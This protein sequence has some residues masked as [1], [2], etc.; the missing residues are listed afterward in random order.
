MVTVKDGVVRARKGYRLG[1]VRGWERETH[2]DEGAEVRS[3]DGGF[4]GAREVG[5]QA[6]QT[7][8]LSGR[9]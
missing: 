8:K 2:R 5:Q 4:M 9:H 6:W 7:G 3:G 1:E